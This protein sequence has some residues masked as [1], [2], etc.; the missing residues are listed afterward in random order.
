M[1][2]RTMH[3]SRPAP[4]APATAAELMAAATHLYVHVPFCN[5]KCLYC[6]FYS[7]RWEKETANRWIE[8]LR[9]EIESTL[10]GGAAPRT[11]YMGGGTPSLLDEAQWAALC[12]HIRTL[13]D[14][15]G[16]EE[17]TVEANP[18]TLSPEKLRLLRGA[19]VTRLSLGAQSFDDRT[20]TFL[21]RRHSADDIRQTADMARDN[22]F[23]HLSL[24]LIAGVPG[25]DG[26]AWKASVQAALALEPDHLSVYALSVEEGS[27]LKARLEAGQAALPDDEA[28][29]DAITEAE[30]ALAHA[31]FARY[32]ISN[33][34][35][36]GHE[37]RHNLAFW[38]G[39]D[40]LGLG[41]AAASRCGPHR[42]T[43]AEDLEGYCSALEQGRPPPRRQERLTDAQD[44]GER[45]V[46]AFRL[47]EGVAVDDFCR[48]RRVPAAQQRQWEAQ[49]ERWATHGLTER[50]AGRWRLT[51][52]GR[53]VAD[54]LAAELLPTAG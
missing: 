8:A 15:R 4:F 30:T 28:A 20:L 53:A 42:W 48:A 7:V 32:E 40:F 51:Q 43:N 10:P 41:P 16:L 3:H 26:P 18:G 31:G 33:Y 54:A 29:E 17:W 46:F 19:G 47:L 45:F 9:Q 23:D 5:G 38:R 12:E 39:G 36:P 52:Q 11:I 34:A 14:L 25:V 22:G 24:D 27:Q 50:R 6:G 2:L 21:G 13:L 49:L 1:L 44:T 37:C 35:L